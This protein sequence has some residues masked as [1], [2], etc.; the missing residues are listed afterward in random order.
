MQT[1]AEIHRAPP[2]LP[3]CSTLRST[4][5]GS[6]LSLLFALRSEVRL[7]AALGVSASRFH[8]LCQRSICSTAFVSRSTRDVPLTRNLGIS[9]SLVLLLVLGSSLHCCSN[10]GEWERF[11]WRETCCLDYHLNSRPEFTRSNEVTYPPLFPSPLKR[12]KKCT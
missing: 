2:P 9:R 5:A 8:F 10:H 6:F 1:R 12:T 7:P 3:A 11:G 4:A